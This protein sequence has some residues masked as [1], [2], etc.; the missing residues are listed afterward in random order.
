MDVNVLAGLPPSCCICCR[1][2]GKSVLKHCYL[3]VVV[4]GVAHVFTDQN[5]KSDPVEHARKERT[6]VTT[7]KV[8]LVE[9][10]IHTHTNKLTTVRQEMCN[11]HRSLEP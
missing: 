9:N 3:R 4:V 8:K 6:S 7:T 10:P 11:T 5:V 2:D 1:E